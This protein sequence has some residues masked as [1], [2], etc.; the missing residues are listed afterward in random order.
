M[1]FRSQYTYT[2]V[3]RALLHIL[4]GMEAG[5]LADSR[6]QD[7]VS[8]ARVLGFRQS[9]A[10]LLHEIKRRGDLPLV[11]KVADA[12]G[13]L[14]PR[15]MAMLRQDLY[16]SHLYQSLVFQKSGKTIKNEYTR[17]VIVRS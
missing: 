16:A 14:P 10:P 6:S 8:Y 13:L 17:S 4:L 1:L 11:T 3:S 15:A 5:E 9:A 2:R 7:Y 12:P